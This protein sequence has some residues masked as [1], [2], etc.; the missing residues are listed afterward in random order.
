MCYTQ[1]IIQDVHSPRTHYPYP[2]K[3]KGDKSTNC[4]G[5]EMLYNKATPERGQQVP[6]GSLYSA[7]Q[8]KA[9]GHWS[10]SGK[11][12]YSRNSHTTVLGKQEE[13]RFPR[14]AE[15]SQFLEMLKNHLNAL[16]SGVRDSTQQGSSGS[17]QPHLLCD[18]MICIWG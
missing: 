1:H 12:D 16:L 15:K 5:W 10:S 8:G 13:H 11:Q 4:H 6:K 3:K 9:W 14:G 2:K 17:F 7:G 18:P